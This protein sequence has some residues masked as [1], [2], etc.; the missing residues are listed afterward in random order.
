[1]LL[2]AIEA[3]N[4]R[5]KQSSIL[6]TTHVQN[7]SMPASNGNGGSLEPNTNTILL[8]LLLLQLTRLLMKSPWYCKSM[9][10]FASDGMKTIVGVNVLHHGVDWLV[11]E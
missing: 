9:E 10:S 3:I 4:V 8:R 2:Q 7:V 11:N 5:Q 6:P 1:L